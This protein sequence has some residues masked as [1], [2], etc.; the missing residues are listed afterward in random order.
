MTFLV[1]WLYIIGGH[2]FLTPDKGLYATF[3]LRN[4]KHVQFPFLQCNKT[5]GEK[6]KQ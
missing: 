2:S 4:N 3:F 1:K 5:L 6:I